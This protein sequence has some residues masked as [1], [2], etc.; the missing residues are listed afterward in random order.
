[1]STLRHTV[2]SSPRPRYLFSFHYTI[3][4]L[5]CTYIVS[6]RGQ[7]HLFK[8]YT[9]ADGLP[10]SRV[11]PI[12]QDS[13]GYMW[14]G[15]Q[16]GLTRYDG[17]EFVSFSGA[18]EIPG[19]FG[20]YI[21][22]D[23]QGAIWFAFTG[24]ARSGVLRYRD[25]DTTDFSAAVSAARP[26]CLAEDPNH[27]IWIGTDKGLTRIRFVDSLRMKWTAEDF[28]EYETRSLFVDTRGMLWV[29]CAN[30]T[31]YT[32][33]GGKFSVAASGV[34]TYLRAYA[35]HER[36]GAVWFGGLKGAYV[37][38]NGVLR[39]F[40]SADGLPD[41]G[42][43]SFCEDWYGNFWVGT[44]KG[45]YRMKTIDAKRRFVKEPSFGDA[46]VYDMC[47]DVEGNVWFASDPGLRKLL[48]SDIIVDFPG[49]EKLATAGFGPIAQDPG[50]TIYFGSRNAGIFTLKN[51]TLTEG[52]KFRSFTD[53]T[54]LA[55][56]PQSATRTWFGIKMG[57]ILLLDGQA[58]YRYP[59][60]VHWVDWSVHSLGNLSDG[61]VLM[62]T[63]RGLFI[64]DR[65]L[66]TQRLQ[67]PNIDSLAVFDIAADGDVYWL[68]TDNGAYAVRIINDTI[69]EVHRP[70]SDI[71]RGGIVYAI[72]ADNRGH[73]WFGTD[74]AGLVHYDGSG[75]MS[76][77]KD[78]GIVGNRIF[79]LAQ[80]SLG[81]I[82]I[83]A[84]SGL[85]QFDGSSFRNFTH[86]QGFG[87]IGLHGLM[88]DKEG[89]LWVSNFPGVSK[90]K[91]Q[92]FSRS[93]RA[94]PIS[95][96]L[97]QV[98]AVDV[99][100]NGN[101]E[102]PPAPSVITFQYAGLS[103][104]DEANIRYRYMLEGFDPGWSSPVVAR[105]VRYTHLASG[106]YTFRVIARSADG[107]WSDRPSVVSFTILPPIW[108]RWWFIVAACMCLF[109]MAYSL[110]RYRLHKAL[111][112][113]RTRSRI[114]M[115][116]HDDI[117]SSLT[118]ISVLSEVA[119]HQE[120]L[121]PEAAAETLTS[122]GNTA[123]DVI[124]SLG[125][126]VWS[127]DPKNDDLQN[128][129]RRI[130]QFGQEMCEGKGIEYETEIADDFSDARLTLEQRRD[131]FLLFKEATHNMVKYSRATRV[132]F[133]ASQKQKG[134]L[135]RFSDNGMGFTERVDSP[136]HG[137]PSM[138]ER[139]KRIGG[140]FSIRSRSGEGTTVSMEVKTG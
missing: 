30:E 63:A 121:N 75:F 12:L 16:A 139:G 21:L 11:A 72:L 103:F 28:P 100:L 3:L 54:V 5:L 88:V 78:D 43:W 10:D 96:A 83:G 82:W 67:H 134:I 97:M 49:K 61:K 27:D 24:F 56:L 110:Y 37:I 7:G 36:R 102:I 58:T 112:L 55:I 119:R 85:S 131:V 9:T 60:T 128:V 74:G 117:G 118:R 57:G 135:L 89:Y 66:S 19:I 45:L 8:D 132:R 137:L 17:K 40:S 39:V 98:D 6:V 80:D 47:L 86:V 140:E 48:A 46:I 109:G 51:N 52:S 92:R 44:A 79:A 95:I 90:L 84:S 120:R 122:I 20:R 22:E 68:G 105:E 94:P 107:V 32:Y 1:M 123:R 108:Q 18:K 38:E 136:G 14:F 33:A 126:I 64:A 127:V 50:G 35:V 59:D 93:K 65:S 53:F 69:H 42:V 111:Q 23:H 113:E 106:T 29:A 34:S 25:K 87:E 104:T 26:S 99:E 41:R 81:S 124:D 138:R 62:G 76:F 73:V 129:I 125:D 71:L 4:L 133:S 77:K 15:T 115:D 130:V 2:T 116:L 70:Q 114:A 101:I 13:K 31:L 91:P